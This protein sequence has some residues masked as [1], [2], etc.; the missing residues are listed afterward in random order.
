MLDEASQLA[1]DE[2]ARLFDA[3]VEVQRGDERLAPV[4]QQRLLSAPSRLLLAAAEQQMVAEAQPLGHA[5]ERRRRDQNGLH[6]RLLALV[7]LGELAEQQIGHD[8]AEHGVAEELER[9]VVHDAAA[10]VLVGARRMRHRVLE[11][12]AVAEPVA[13]RRLQRLELVTQANE[14]AALELGPVRDR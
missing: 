12:A 13:G 1:H 8:E 2:R 5:R 4:G 14:L 7:V 11:Q 9:F 10:R 6:L 3:A